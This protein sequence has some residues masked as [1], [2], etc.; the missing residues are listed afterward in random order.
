MPLVVLD[1]GHLGAVG[2]LK[3]ARGVHLEADVV[4]AVA[5]VIVPDE[6][7]SEIY[8]LIREGL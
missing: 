3:G 4:H 8:S 1:E 5:L 6:A 7:M 2:R